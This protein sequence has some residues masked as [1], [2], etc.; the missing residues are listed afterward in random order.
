MSRIKLLIPMFLVIFFLNGCTSTPNEP[1]IP[2]T[3]SVSCGTILDNIGDFD[4]KKL[5]LVP[6]DGIILDE[7][8]VYFEQGE[9]VF[10]VLSR[11]LKKREIHFEFSQTPI[12]NSV[13]IEGIGNIYEFDCGELSGW[14]YSVNGVFPNF[15]C[16]SY[17]LEEN[18]RIEWKYTCDLGKDVQNGQELS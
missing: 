5:E 6:Y 16:S 2:C 9:T 14:N 15:G 13:Y 4:A 10:D 18:D 12:Y 11:E 7:T 3:I 8:T 1:N 17:T